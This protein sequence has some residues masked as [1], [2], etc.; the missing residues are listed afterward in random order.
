MNIVR[1]Q[2]SYIEPYPVQVQGESFYRRDI[3]DISNY[4]G[5]EDGVDADDFIAHL[6]LEDDNI[7]DPDN[8][9]RVDIDNKTVGHLSKPAAKKYR[10]RLAD[11][12]LS[13][14]IGECF[15]SIKGGFA[16][17]TGGA[18]DFGVRLDI[19]LDDLKVYIPPVSK[20]VEQIQ[21]P[22][23]VPQT[24]PTPPPTPQKSVGHLK[25]ITDWFFA[26]SKY[27]LLRILLL[28]FVIIPCACSACLLAMQAVV[29]T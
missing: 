15:A 24:S 8:A 28:F 16:L 12:G 13:D 4:L 7:H 23:P 2:S 3:E 17:R 9:V 20:P 18:A 22:I 27:R 14:V 1:F 10:Q 6:I 19:D 11:L 26:P 29:G 25:R 21:P 5:E